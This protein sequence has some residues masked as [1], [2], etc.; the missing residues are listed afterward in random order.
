MDVLDSGH[1]HRW[2]GLILITMI[3]DNFS[4]KFGLNDNSKN[5][6]N[7]SIERQFF[8][9]ITNFTPSSQY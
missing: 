2:S 5:A 3:W 9:E 7:S 1:G 6:L 8:K 4:R